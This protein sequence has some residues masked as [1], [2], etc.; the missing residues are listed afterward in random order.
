M[1]LE[2][3]FGFAVDQWGV[4]KG[5]VGIT[6]KYLFTQRDTGK[7]GPIKSLRDRDTLLAVLLPVLGWAAILISML[8]RSNA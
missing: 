1:M 6:E 4:C 7:N 8:C 2:N 5:K 3:D